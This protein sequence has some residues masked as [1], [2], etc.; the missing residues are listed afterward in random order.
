MLPTLAPYSSKN[1]T[2][3]IGDLAHV[4]YLFSQYALS[5]NYRGSIG[6]Q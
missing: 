3:W 1:K 2:E 6:K 5:A 4:P